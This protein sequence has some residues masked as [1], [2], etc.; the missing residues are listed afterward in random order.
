MTVTTI[1]LDPDV[2]SLAKELTGA[3]SNRDVVTR[4]LQTLIAIRRQP[5][6]V[7]RVIER[8]FT[9]EQIAAST[10]HYTAPHTPAGL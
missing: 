8:Q 6:A 2:L 10:A 7:E 1:D 9:D 5:A 3:R 4:A